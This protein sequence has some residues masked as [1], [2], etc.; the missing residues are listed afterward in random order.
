MSQSR[1]SAVP[2]SEDRELV[3]QLLA[4]PGEQLQA[5]VDGG[6]R[7]QTAATVASA[8][9][10]ALA[11]TGRG[12]NL[13]EAELAGLNLSNLDLR[14]ATLSR[15]RLDSADLSGADLRGATLICPLTERTTFRGAKLDEVYAHAFSAVSADWSGAHMP[16]AI[17]T[18]G[19]L[20]HGVNLTRSVL[21]G[22]NYAGATFYQCDL[23]GANLS[24]CDLT[25]A[26]FNE[27]V[28]RDTVLTGA[29]LAAGTITRSSMDGSDLRQTRGV[30]LTLQQITAMSDVQMDD[31]CLPE[32]SVRSATLRRLRARGAVFTGGRFSDIGADSCEFH[33]SDLTETLLRA[34][35]GRDNSFS[36]CAL[37]GASLARCSLPG[38]DFRGA[39]MENARLLECQLPESRFT[40][41]NSDGGGAVGFV[42]RALV[43]R[44]CDLASAQFTRAY[45]YRASFTGDPVI[46]MRMDQVDM[47]GANLIQA[48]VAAAMPGAVLKGVNAAYSRF[49]QSDLRAA[50]L[51]GA[52]LFEASFVK[53]SL[54]DADLTAV[55]APLFV[56]RCPGLTSARMDEGLRGWTVQ[57]AATLARERIAST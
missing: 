47:T 23:T 45:L 46:G 20:F 27:C 53:T 5:L 52:T 18:T 25:G 38:S 9:A 7:A 4:R 12:L 40:Q 2:E 16:G 43:V 11:D 8:T 6:N 44:D 17:D 21:S 39:N 3:A 56:D 29:T 49:N 51:K 54:H 10:R 57:L 13:S 19:S 34:V 37:V 36:C 50:D 1:L 42:G 31:A 26:T 48:Y 14:G 24:G 30:G 35:R 22:G 15:A 41:Y 33:G 32:L 28:L 55:R